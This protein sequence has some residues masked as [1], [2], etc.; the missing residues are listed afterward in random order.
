MP[1]GPSPAEAE[2]AALRPGPRRP[3]AP[4]AGSRPSA[5]LG[6][7]GIAP[8]CARRPEAWPPPPLG[9]RPEVAGGVERGG[10]RRLPPARA[11]RRRAGR[12]RWSRARATSGVLAR[13]RPATNPAIWLERR[14][15]GAARLQL[16]G[17]VVPGRDG[18]DVRQAV[19]PLRGVP[20]EVDERHEQ[21]HEQHQ[22]RERGKRKE[23]RPCLI[24]AR[25]DGGAW[26]WA[27]IGGGGF[28]Q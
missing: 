23:S 18:G 2:P 10:P 12:R 8:A 17:A 16:D 22:E 20:P 6:A 14:Q 19:A 9:S 3:A 28:S 27:W 25:E 5:G 4:A 13:Q 7:D 1:G 21:C 11:C 26:W 15:L 24:I